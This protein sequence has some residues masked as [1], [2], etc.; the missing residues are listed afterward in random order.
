MHRHGTGRMYPA[1]G[2]A[3][4]GGECILRASRPRGRMHQVRVCL[5]CQHVLQVHT[6]IQTSYMN[7]REKISTITT[8]SFSSNFQSRLEFL[9]LVSKSL[10]QIQYIFTYCLFSFLCFLF[11]LSTRQ[12]ADDHNPFEHSAMNDMTIR[13]TIFR[14]CSDACRTTV[15]GTSSFLRYAGAIQVRIYISR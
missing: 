13:T 10:R 6:I 4:V 7:C 2:G 15:F 8:L 1:H 14:K 12:L 9:M 5:L 11:F 3:D